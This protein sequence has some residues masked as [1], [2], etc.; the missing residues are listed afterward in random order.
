MTDTTTTRS[1]V[2]EDLISRL[3]LEEKVAQLYGVWV[4]A[5]ADGASNVVAR[6]ADKS[7]RVISAPSHR[8]AE[9]QACITMQV[10][11]S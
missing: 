4:G 5:N 1:D 9:A 2:V 10:A 7:R 3:T 8:S 11:V 6:E